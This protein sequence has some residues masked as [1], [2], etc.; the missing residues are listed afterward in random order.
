MTRPDCRTLFGDFGPIHSELIYKSNLFESFLSCAL[1]AH[2]SSTMQK[3]GTGWKKGE[4]VVSDG[5]SR[6]KRKKR[7][8]SKYCPPDLDGAEVGEYVPP[9]QKAMKSF[10]ACENF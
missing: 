7:R 4:C 5:S 1:V 6:K 10:K 3:A 8:N 2:N 9:A